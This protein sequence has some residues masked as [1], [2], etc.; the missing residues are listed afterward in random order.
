MDVK[1]VAAPAI[2]YVALEKTKEERRNMDKTKPLTILNCA[3]NLPKA[4]FH[5]F[6]FL[7]SSQNVF[8]TDS[9][10]QKEF[11]TFSVSILRLFSLQISIL[12]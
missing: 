3:A 1:H 9:L 7:Y 5:I 2:L 10:A 12:Q 4:A 11:I 6:L 8:H